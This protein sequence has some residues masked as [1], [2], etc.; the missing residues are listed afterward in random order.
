MKRNKNNEIY[1]IREYYLPYGTKRILFIENMIWYFPSMPKS[2]IQ[3]YNIYISEYTKDNI[4]FCYKYY[5]SEIIYLHIIYIFIHLYLYL[6]IL[7]ILF[8]IYII[9]LYYL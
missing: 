5:S 8:I 2:G 1:F 6:F 3:I 4:Y 9:N 7:F